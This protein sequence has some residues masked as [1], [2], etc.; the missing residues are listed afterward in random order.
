MWNLAQKERNLKNKIANLF[1][2]LLSTRQLFRLEIW[3]YV[4]TW[5]ANCP[6][7]ASHWPVWGVWEFP[8]KPCVIT[9]WWDNGRCH[10]HSRETMPHNGLGQSMA[11]KEKER[12][13]SSLVESLLWRPWDRYSGWLRLEM[14]KHL[15]IFV[16]QHRQHGQLPTTQ[17]MEVLGGSPCGRCGRWWFWLLN[18]LSF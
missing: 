3:K 11:F 12:Q 8:R 15:I 14:T 4:I 13:S 9:S 5:P 16:V 1:P 17:V 6:L 2:P 7:S 10:S 18:L